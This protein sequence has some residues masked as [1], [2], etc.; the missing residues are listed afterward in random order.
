MLDMKQLQV[1]GAIIEYQGKILCMQ[2]NKGKYSYTSYKFEFP[3]GKVEEGEDGPSALMRELREEMA[4]EVSISEK[5]YVTSVFYQY[6]DFAITMR[7]YL[8]KPLTDRFVRKEHISSVWLEP[9]KLDTL[10]WAAADIP[11]MREVMLLFA[12]E[13]KEHA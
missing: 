9:E 10:D 1:V 2:R 3:G 8:C 12:G 7:C 5:D 11:V 6:P 13:G 4:M